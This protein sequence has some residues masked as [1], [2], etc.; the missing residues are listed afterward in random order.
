[1]PFILLMLATRLEDPRRLANR[2][3]SLEPKPDVGWGEGIMTT[4]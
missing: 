3:Y 4:R 2:R 1:M